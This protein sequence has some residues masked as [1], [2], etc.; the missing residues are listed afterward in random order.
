MLKQE[1]QAATA[2]VEK[3]GYLPLALEQAGSYIH[4]RQYSFNRYLQEYETNITHLLRGKW[5]IGKNPSNKSIFATWELSFSAIQ[6]QN[7]KAAELLLVCGFLDNNDISDELL[8]RGM[9]LPE[10]GKNPFLP[11]K[12]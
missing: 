11:P 1:Q 9:K 4:S 3:L 12:G 2:I 8:W 7:S 10:D 5:R 6:E